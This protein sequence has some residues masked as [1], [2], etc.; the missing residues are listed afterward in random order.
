MVLAGVL[1]ALAT[2]S[3]GCDGAFAGPPGGSAVGTPGTDPLFG[4][5]VFT[6]A[7]EN[8]IITGFYNDVWFIDPGRDSDDGPAGVTGNW[9]ADSIQALATAGFTGW[10]T[11]EQSPGLIEV[12]NQY[13]LTLSFM[14]QWFL[15]NGDGSRKKEFEVFTGNIVYSPT[16]LDINFV[17]APVQR[18]VL[19]GGQVVFYVDRQSYP[20]GA[21]GSAIFGWTSPPANSPG[22][23]PPP[24]SRFLNKNYSEI[25]CVLLTKLLPAGSPQLTQALGVTLTDNTNNENVENLGAIPQNAGGGFAAVASPTGVFGDLFALDFRNAPVIQPTTP[26]HDEFEAVIEYARHYGA[27]HTNLIAQAV[28]LSSGVVGTLTDPEMV[29]WQNGFGYSFIQADLDDLDKLH[30]PGEDRDP[31]APQ[32]P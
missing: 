17:T 31:N 19:P 23:F 15:R 2:T 22:D 6:F 12:N 1:G 21:S 5:T 32:S 18:I 9:F 11:K 24:Q 10:L 29:V 3:T 30:L 27:L 26:G 7:V 13:P 25:G 16:S 4:V 28:G 20:T 8:P 14:S